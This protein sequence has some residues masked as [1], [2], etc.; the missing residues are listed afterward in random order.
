M[1]TLRELD[2]SL[3]HRFGQVSGSI[4]VCSFIGFIFM[5]LP[6]CFLQFFNGLNFLAP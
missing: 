4:R 3:L 5:L 6:F 2:S 1:V